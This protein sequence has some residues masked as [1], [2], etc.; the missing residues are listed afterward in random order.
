MSVRCRRA[1]RAWQTRP[2]PLPCHAVP[3][4]PIAIVSGL[5]MSLIGTAYGF[6]HGRAIRPPHIA[7]FM[8]AAGMFVF[9]AMAGAH[10]LQAA[11]ASVWLTGAAAGASQYLGLAVF[12]AALRRGPLSP[13]WCAAAMTFLPAVI[14]AWI[15]LGE[16]RS[17]A[18]V[19]GVALACA[20]VVLAALHGSRGRDPSARRPLDARTA[21]V[22][23]L[24]LATIVV[25]AGS[26]NVSM[27]FLGH[28]PAPGGR[29]AMSAYGLVMLA[30]CYAVFGICMLA[31][32]LARPPPVAARGRLLPLGLV[33]AVGSVGGFALLRCAASAPA[34][35]VFT[36]NSVASLLGTSLVSVVWLRERTT[37]AWIGMLVTGCAAVVLVGW[38]G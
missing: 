32:T 37:P 8:G 31:D 3:A 15:F 4:I 29:D 6:G 23:G 25:L 12:G 33:A 38:P 24:L 13:A 9:A 17:G 34:A 5:L 35:Q 10:T 26:I 20:S 14:Y 18:N 1:H 21:C 30:A 36:A 27:K 16:R 22:Y 28:R 11:P 19:A 2:L 7:V